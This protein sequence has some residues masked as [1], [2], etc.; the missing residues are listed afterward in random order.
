LA[1]A[2]FARTINSL[3]RRITQQIEAGRSIAFHG[4]NPG[5]ANFLYATGLND[6][7]AAIFDA[8]ESK[9]GRFLPGCST[10]IRHSNDPTYGAADC[11]WIAA[12]GYADEIVAHAVSRRGV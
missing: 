9:A 1:E 3:G 4:A 10:P 2:S 8:D 6:R 7:P 5:L 12:L 11:I